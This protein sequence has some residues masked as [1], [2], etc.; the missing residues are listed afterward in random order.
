MNI[1]L[2]LNNYMSFDVALTKDH[3]KQL[4]VMALVDLLED[5][6]SNMNKNDITLWDSTNEVIGNL[7]TVAE[8]NMLEQREVPQ[9]WVTLMAEQAEMMRSA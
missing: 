8:L 4:A 2:P 1:K 6:E 3:G 9:G 5:I 7:A